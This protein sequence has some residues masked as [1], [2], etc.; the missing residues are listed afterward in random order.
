MCTL[1]SAFWDESQGFFNPRLCLNPEIQGLKWPTAWCSGFHFLIEIL[2]QGIS[3]TCYRGLLKST[4][5]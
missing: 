3:I 2:L 1:T 4:C 5:R